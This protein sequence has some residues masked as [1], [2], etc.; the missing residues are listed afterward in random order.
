MTKKR[1]K[2]YQPKKCNRSLLY[3]LADSVTPVD[4]NEEMVDRTTLLF[5]GE[6]FV[7]D[8]ATEEDFVMASCYF[9]VGFYL[10]EHFEGELNLYMRQCHQFLRD[11][12]QE[13]VNSGHINA[14][15]APLLQ[16]GIVVMDSMREK[17]TKPQITRACELASQQLNRAVST[18][19]GKKLRLKC[20]GEIYLG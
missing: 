1:N 7:K 16:E 2:K 5:V 19:V 3:R 6:K 8:E 10:A 18:D 11:V 17:A 15:K 9:R 4:E 14:D 12:H 13:W 20:K